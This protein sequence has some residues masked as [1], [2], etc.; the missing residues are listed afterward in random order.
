MHVGIYGEVNYRYSRVRRSMA[1]VRMQDIACHVGVSAVTVHNALT[2]QK[3][4]SDAVREK[5]VDAAREM[6]YF[7]D[8]RKSTCLRHVGVLISEKWL[9]D[10]TTFYWKLYMEMALEAPNRNCMVT[11]EILKHGAEAGLKLPSFVGENA[12][13][14]LVVM[15]EI[16]RKYIDFL[17]SS[18]KIPIIYLDFYY[19]EISEDAVVTDGFYGMYMVTEYLYEKGFR[20]MAYVGSIHATS[21]I[22]DRFCGFQ[23]VLLE[24]ELTLPEEWRMEDRDE[25]GEIILVLPEKLPEAFVCNCDLVAIKLI[26]VLEKQG[27]KVPED[28][29]VVGFDNYLYPGLPDRKITT[30]EVN[31]KEL[32]QVALKKV[33]KRMEDPGAMK[34]MDLVAGHIVEKE[35]VRLPDSK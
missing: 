24:H 30:Y 1:K 12:V 10:Y 21:S 8:Q 9:A 34:R 20:R 5:I 35:S 17:R 16:G 2:G 27:Y 33:L 4:V 25:T 6:G 13:E 11:A 22:M 23:R 28:V 32:A 31:M 7:Q 29:T 15:G 14:G 18:V 26:E 19:K 3:G